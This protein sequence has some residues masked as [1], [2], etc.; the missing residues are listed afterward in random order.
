MIATSAV[1][2]SSPAQQIAAVFPFPLKGAWLETSPVRLGLGGTAT[3]SLIAD[4]AEALEELKGQGVV[5]R[6]VGEL[7]EYLL[8]FPGIVDVLVDA[9]RAVKE[10]FGEGRLLLRMY[11]DPEEEDRYPC[12]CVRVR[13]YNE[14]FIER[15]KRAEAVFIDR[16][17]TVEGWLQ[18]TTDF[19]DPGKANGF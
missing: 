4:I 18:L 16:L 15:L 12:L 2:V 10:Q 13:E 11:R 7:Q 1:S 19:E 5:V 6:D 14:R 17:A 9:V 3:G 8:R